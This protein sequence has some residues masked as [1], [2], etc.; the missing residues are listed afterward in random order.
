MPTDPKAVPLA[1]YRGTLCCLI[2]FVV[3][4]HWYSGPATPPAAPR[5]QPE[6]NFNPFAD[7][8]WSAAVQ[9]QS[10]REQSAPAAYRT[11]AYR[12]LRHQPQPT[13]SAEPQSGLS[14]WRQNPQL[15]RERN[16]AARYQEELRKNNNSNPQTHWGSF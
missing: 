15:Y 3:A 9:E 8:L 1:Q 14:F 2:A 11:Q 12:A 16:D 7:M 6:V 10:A 5:A 4:W 13:K